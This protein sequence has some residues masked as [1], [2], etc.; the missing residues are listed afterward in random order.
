MTQIK[1][2]IKKAMIEAMKAKDQPR[3]LIVRLALNSIKSLEKDRQAALSEEETLQ[4]L[5]KMVKQGEESERQYRAASRE[6]LAHQEAAE[7]AI[8]RSFLPTP[9]SED[10]L[11]ALIADAI[12]E[13]GAQNIKDMGKMMAHLKPKVTGRADLG[14]VS[15]TIRDLLS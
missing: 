4:V 1:D 3:L 13:F 5:Q 9:L 6:D 11:Q 2:E 8:I 7:V 14:K 10:E 12:T 15:Q